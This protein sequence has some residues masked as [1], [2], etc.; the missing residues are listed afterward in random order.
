MKN[1]LLLGAVAILAV[2]GMR[3]CDR[4]T[5]PTDT[6]NSA[7]SSTAKEAE[8]TNN[9]II[10][11]TEKAAATATKKISSSRKMANKKYV[12]KRSSQKATVAPVANA[13][14]TYPSS[15][16]HKSRRFVFGADN[17]K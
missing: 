4:N 17:T 9:A 6:A 11:K 13:T 7:A 2:L 8:R 15:D 10:K 1:V 16:H 14:S 5:A 3:S 12:A